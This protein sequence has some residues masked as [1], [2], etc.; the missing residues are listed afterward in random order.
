MFVESTIDAVG[1]VNMLQTYLEPFI[2]SVYPNGVTF[3]QD[4]APSH[5]AQYTRDYFAIAGITDL[6]WPPCSPDMNIIEN[7]W[8]A[9]SLAVYEG[10]RQYH[11]IDD[12]KETLVY[13]W[14]KLSVDDIRKLVESMPRRVNAQLT[15]KGRTTKY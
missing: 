2:D 14:E 1:Y 12:L 3:Q 13:E 10:W 6:S 4:G 11:S 5:R 9:L 15:S 8:R 7:C